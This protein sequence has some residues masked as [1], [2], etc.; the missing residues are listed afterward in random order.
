[1]EEQENS[2]IRGRL[3]ALKMPL[4]IPVRKARAFPADQEAIKGKAPIRMVWRLL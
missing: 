3:Q 2:S 1:M 4:Q